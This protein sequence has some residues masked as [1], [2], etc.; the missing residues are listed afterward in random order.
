MMEQ[1]TAYLLTLEEERLRTSL[2]EETSLL[3]REVR[4]VH[5]MGRGLALKLWPEAEY[6]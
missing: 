5:W 4:W 3:W 2:L 1:Q 6:P